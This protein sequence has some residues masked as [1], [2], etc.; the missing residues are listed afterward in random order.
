MARVPSRRSSTSL[1]YLFNLTIINNLALQIGSASASAVPPATLA[2]TNSEFAPQFTYIQLIKTVE[3]V[4]HSPD[5]RKVVFEVRGRNLNHGMPIRVT[6]EA[7][8]R[9]TVCE[10]LNPKLYNVSEVWTQE[11]VRARYELLVP[12][13]VSK[14]GAVLYFC[15]PYQVKGN[16]GRIPNSIF[17]SEFYKWY[18]QG[19]DLFL[20]ISSLEEDHAPT[21]DSMNG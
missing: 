20:N 2:H 19:R 7:A 1:F 12:K 15:L 8:D 6:E 9:Q 11:F 13:V 21:A 4:Q 10:D 18:H 14:Q 3:N 5:Q 17:K 16:D